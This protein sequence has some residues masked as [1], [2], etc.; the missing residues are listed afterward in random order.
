[1]KCYQE[2]AHN[3]DRLHKIKSLCVLLLTLC[4]VLSG[5]DGGPAR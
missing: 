4:P 5:C 1:M 3:M 2:E